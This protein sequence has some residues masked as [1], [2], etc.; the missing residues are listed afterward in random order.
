MKL[1]TVPEPAP[2]AGALLKAL[3]A[4]PGSDTASLRA[5]RRGVS[6]AWAKAP[7]EA[8]FAVAFDLHERRLHRWVAYELVRSH[9]TAFAAVDDAMLERFAEGLGSWDAVD[10]FARILS[11]PAWVS[12]RASDG[13]IDA[14]AGASDRWLRRTALVST[15]ALNSRGDGGRGDAARTLSICARLAGDRDD[16]VEKALSWALRALAKPC[17]EAVRAFLDAEDARLVARVRR[18]VGNKLR[19]G[20]KSPRNGP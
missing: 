13:L 16:M 15:V 1:H 3:A 17:P 9:K 19:T 12:G 5:V 7:A 18:E 2:D 11:G 14:W 20:V 10:A 8:V 6:A 4:A